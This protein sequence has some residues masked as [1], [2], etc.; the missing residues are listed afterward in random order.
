M[1]YR[2]NKTLQLMVVLMWNINNFL[3]YRML[4][5]WSTHRKLACPYHMEK[6]IHADE[7]WQNNFF[8]N[9]IDDSCQQITNYRKNKN[10]FFLEEL[11]WMLH[12]RNHKAKNGITWC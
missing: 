11:R 3:P 10:D 5:G 9:V 8:L 6:S 7:R 2:E 12:C 1:I 4:S